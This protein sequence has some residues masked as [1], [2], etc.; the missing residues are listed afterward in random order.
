MRRAQAARAEGERLSCAPAAAGVVQ[1][2]RS[3]QL[4]L[5]VGGVGAASVG[6]VGENR[7]FS[8]ARAAGEI[9]GRGTERVAGDSS[10][11]P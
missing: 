8:S 1:L 10:A 9:G 4:Q 6:D 2:L 5:S 11:D 3:N 7:V